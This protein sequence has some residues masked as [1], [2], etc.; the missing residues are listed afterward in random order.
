[1][2]VV[3][4]TVY[5]GIAS[6]VFASLAIILYFLREIKKMDQRAERVIVEK[7]N[8]IDEHFLKSISII[9]LLMLKRMMKQIPSQ[10]KMQ[11]KDF[12]QILGTAFGHAA[13]EIID[14]P[15]SELERSVVDMEI[16]PELS[17]ILAIRDEDR[18]RIIDLS[19]LAF[20]L[21]KLVPS[22][23]GRFIDRMT[24]SIVCG[25][26]CGLLL[27]FVDL[28]YNYE[29]TAYLPFLGM[30]ILVSGGLYLDY[31]IFEIWRQRNLEKSL[32]DLEKAKGLEE[33]RECLEEITKYAE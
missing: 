33:M 16:P 6:L 21:T 14:K 30:L 24:K 15:E 2:L 18:D 26:F 3:Q 1:M 8:I 12:S 27:A 4:I 11:A 32:K 7:N 10:F 31:G 13:T 5:Q 19:L 20:F 29:L 28:L 9:S 23:I 25:F 17:S 22:V